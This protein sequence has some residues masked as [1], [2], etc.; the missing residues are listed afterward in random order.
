MTLKQ[1]YQEWCQE[2]GKNGGVLIGPS[3]QEFLEW[4][5]GY[6][7]RHYDNMSL[8]FTERLSQISPEDLRIWFEKDAQNNPDEPIVFSGPSFLD[9]KTA[10]AFLQERGYLITKNGEIL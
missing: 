4:A 5:D 9:E 7:K 2:T 10:I 3:I 1:K 8:R 6:E